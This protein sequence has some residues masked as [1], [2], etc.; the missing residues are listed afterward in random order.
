VKGAETTPIPVVWVKATCPECGNYNRRA[1]RACR[2]C[3]HTGLVWKTI[4]R[5]EAD[6]LG[7]AYDESMER[8]A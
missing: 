4:P 8:P 6:R 3:H 7:L 2:N 5:D 1:R